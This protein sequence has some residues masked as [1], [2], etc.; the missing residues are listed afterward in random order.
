MKKIAVGL[1]VGLLAVLN[2]QPTQ[3]G[4]IKTI[5]IIDTA[6]D[7]S[8]FPNV[9]YEACFTTNKT[10]PNKTNLQEGIGSA[11][12][13]NWGLSGIDHGHNIIQA[14][15][16]TNPNIK[17]VFIRYN[18]ENSKIGFGDMNSMAKALE[19]I[20]QNSSK[21][22]IGA[23][24]ISQAS[25]LYTSTTCSNHT[26]FNLTKSSVDSLALKSI[27]VLAAT[28]NN[29]N[30]N[31]VG[32]P[33]CVDGIVGVGSANINGLEKYTNY[34]QGL[35]LVTNGLVRVKYFSKWNATIRGVSCSTVNV[36]G[37]PI[38]ATQQSYCTDQSSGTSV[39]S[40][41]AATLL[42]TNMKTN[43]SDLIASLPKVKGYSF[44]TK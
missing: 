24:S 25:G 36:Y 34:G 4:E 11:N 33:S 18:D 19:W 9:I 14:A 44:I 16:Q 17:I 10:C 30:P 22:N 20:S 8:K 42:V 26:A 12:V 35:D 7:S 40:P 1:V 43:A 2:V 27:P 28:G 38:T 21:F 39:S 15:I 41:I 3:A 13:S 29:G 31:Q 32:F 37:T 6:I 23:V 5:A